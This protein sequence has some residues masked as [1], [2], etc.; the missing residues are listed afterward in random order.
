MTVA[1]AV[2]LKRDGG[3]VAARAA[4]RAGN[5]VDRGV[6][7]LKFTPVTLALLTLT[8]VLAGVKVNPDLLGVTV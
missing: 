1:L 3:A 5:T 8:G 2:P 7:A 4:D 6:A